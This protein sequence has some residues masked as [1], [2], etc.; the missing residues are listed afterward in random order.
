MGSSTY[1]VKILTMNTYILIVLTIT[2]FSIQVRGRRC[3]NC[4]NGE[5]SGPDNSLLPV[6]MCGSF[7]V[8][9]E[10]IS[11]ECPRTDRCY[12]AS[13]NETLATLDGTFTIQGDLHVCSESYFGEYFCHDKED[14]CYDHN[15]DY[16]DGYGSVQANFNFCCCTSDLCNSR[17]NY[18]YEEVLL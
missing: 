11:M 1:L 12:T 6:A 17:M 7:D 4:L 3:F 8:S 15:L 2:S 14:G 18:D 5:H 9:D 10:T 13:L 16:E